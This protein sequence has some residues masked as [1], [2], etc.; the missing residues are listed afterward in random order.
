MSRITNDFGSFLNKPANGNY[1]LKAPTDQ[2]STNGN[3]V[4]TP[5]RPRLA[6]TSELNGTPISLARKGTS[7][8]IASPL[9]ARINKE[10]QQLNFAHPYDVFQFKV[11]REASD[12]D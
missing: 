5:N 7:E 9:I 12:Q 8:R 3:K 4:C 1:L 10:N 2:S 11:S 6:S